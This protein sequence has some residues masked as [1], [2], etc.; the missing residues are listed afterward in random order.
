MPDLQDLGR[1]FGSLMH[2]GRC[3][4]G[5]DR[6]KVVSGSSLSVVRDIESLGLRVVTNGVG[7]VNVVKKILHEEVTQGERVA[8]VASSPSFNQ[9]RDGRLVAV[10]VASMMKDK[11]RLEDIFVDKARLEAMALASDS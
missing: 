7:E 8:A 1:K 10:M 6:D 9:C 3:A 2:G 4:V 11:A 5:K